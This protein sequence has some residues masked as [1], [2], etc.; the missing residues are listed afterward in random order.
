MREQLAGLGMPGAWEGH[1]LPTLRRVT[2]ATMRSAQER[3]EPRRG[4]FEVYGLDFV[5]DETL[6]PWLIE[7]NESPNLSAH[8]SE[9]K[10]R[11]LPVMLEQLV[12]L[13]VDEAEAHPDR[14]P[15][16]VGAAVGGWT[17]IHGEAPDAAADAPPNLDAL[18]LDVV[19]T[20]A[21]LHRPAAPER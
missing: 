8:G 18:T 9:L 17:L 20:K 13:L 16:R 3:A 6:E 14:A 5:L 21:P 10:A 19:G 15:R 1:I 2:A 11:M 4:S 12:A 7:V